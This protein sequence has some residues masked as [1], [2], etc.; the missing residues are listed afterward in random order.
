MRLLTLIGLFGGLSGVVSA[1]DNSTA[2]LLVVWSRPTHPDLTDEVFNKWYTTE[3]IHDMVKSGLTDLVVR[4]KN[5][6]RLAKYPYLAIY[7]LPDASKVDDPEIMVSIPM[8][9][10]L[11]PGKEKGSKGGAY[12][13]IMDMDMQSY[14]RTQT[15][16]SQIRKTGRGK[17]L[18]T[19]AVEPAVGTD[20]D[21]DSW[22]R[23]Q[24]LDMLR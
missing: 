6:N 3:H 2:G 22:Y 14:K 19:A 7:R 1:A 15:F 24:H 5:V 12:P 9:S 11:L 4:Y 10:N 20:A 17:G 23:L 16:E 18:S 13:D 8:T 21:F